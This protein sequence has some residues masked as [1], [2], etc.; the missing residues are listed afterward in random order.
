MHN[1]CQ[2]EVKIT[3]SG[4]NSQKAIEA[5]LTCLEDDRFWARLQTSFQQDFRDAV[6]EMTGE[7]HDYT[8]AVEEHDLLRYLRMKAQRY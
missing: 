5:V 1:K 2:L 6:R 7:S 8:V 3:H 4:E